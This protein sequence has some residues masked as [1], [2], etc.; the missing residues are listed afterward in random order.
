[1]M[2]LLKDELRGAKNFA[3]L[4]EAGCGKSELSMEFALALAALGDRPVHFFDLDMSKPLFRS[5]DV[6]GELERA[7]VQVHFEEQFMDAPTQTGGVS[8]LLRDRGCY[9]VLDIGGDYIGARAV[10]GYAPLLNAEDTR[11]YYLI[12]PYRP[13]S[14]DL[15]H[16]DGVLTQVLGVSHIRADR[17][18]FVANP[19]FGGMTT[20]QEV[21]NGM[22]AL[23][24]T[25]SGCVT[26]AFCCVR[27][28]LASAVR[29]SVPVFPVKLRLTY[30][31]EC[32]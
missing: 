28:E 23:E 27:A 15:A 4:G 20:E 3:F 12:N 22:R 31:W 8:R 9:V 18:R 6:C 16:I 7:G 17:L 25:L 10:G 11:V 5:R 26:L 21:E 29:V 32:L 14:S 24:Q 1:M 13:W 19:N 2:F 30:Q